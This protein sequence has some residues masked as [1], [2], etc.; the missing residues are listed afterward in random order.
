MN[1]AANLAANAFFFGDH[2]QAPRIILFGPWAYVHARGLRVTD[3]VELISE[4]LRARKHLEA[5]YARV[6]LDSPQALAT[7]RHLAK[8]LQARR[9]ARA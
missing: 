7:L 9:T 5:L 4:E 6:L 8:S 3:G 2:G 1:P